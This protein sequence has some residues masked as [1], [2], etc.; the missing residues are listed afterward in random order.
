LGA[1]YVSLVGLHR[2][3]LTNE[4]RCVS[5]TLRKFFTD[6]KLCIKDIP[7]AYFEHSPNSD[8]NYDLFGV[9][10]DLFEYANWSRE[11]IA[12][13]VET[14]EEKGVLTDHINPCVEVD[15]QIREAMRFNI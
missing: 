3:G 7:D 11:A 1:I 2:E 9:I 13:W 10:N 4:E 5:D 15:D 8:W 6:K 14:L 12:M